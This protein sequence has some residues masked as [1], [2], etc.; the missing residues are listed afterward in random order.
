MLCCSIINTVSMFGG[1][2]YVAHNNIL[3]CIVCAYP[4]HGNPLLHILDLTHLVLI[5]TS[6]QSR[7][8]NSTLCHGEFIG[9]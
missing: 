2:D 5:A 6:S 1:V 9:A 7:M 8:A 4:L 3:M